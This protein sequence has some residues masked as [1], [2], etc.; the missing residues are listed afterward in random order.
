MVVLSKINDGFGLQRQD[1]Q[2]VVDGFGEGAV[3]GD[4]EEG[5]FA[6]GEGVISNSPCSRSS[7][8]PIWSFLNNLTIFNIVSVVLHGFININEDI[9]KCSLIPWYSKLI[10]WERG[11]GHG[12]FSEFL[13]NTHK[14]P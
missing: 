6:E 5:D 1:S 7:Q 10:Y 8:T 2:A 4:G 14:S 9:S 13:P 12:C 11:L 3:S